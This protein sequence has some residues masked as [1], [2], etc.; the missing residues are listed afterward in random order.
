[1]WISNVDYKCGLQI[2]KKGFDVE[3]KYWNGFYTSSVKHNL[4]E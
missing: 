2:L 1:M 3:S 4:E